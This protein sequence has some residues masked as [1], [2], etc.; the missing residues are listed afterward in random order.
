MNENIIHKN[1]ILANLFFLFIINEIRHITNIATPIILI[2]FTG[3][4]QYASL[5]IILAAG[6]IN[7]DFTKL[8]NC[9]N[10]FSSIDPPVFSIFMLFS[11]PFTADDTDYN[12]AFIAPLLKIKI[13][14]TSPDNRIQKGSQT[15]IRLPVRFYVIVYF[16][17]F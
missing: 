11:R 12:F 9:F 8:V 13:A 6:A 15:F 16:N 3:S 2:D 7:I 14:G 5:F 4:S 10:L 17:K 1:D